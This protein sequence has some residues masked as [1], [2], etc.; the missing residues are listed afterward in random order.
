M[1]TTQEKMVT[2]SELAEPSFIFIIQTDAFKTL[3][4]VRNPLGDHGKLGVLI[5]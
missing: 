5:Q 2:F 1:E 3:M 4:Y